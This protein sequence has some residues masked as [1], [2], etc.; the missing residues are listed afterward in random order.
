M[1]ARRRRLD[2]ELLVDSA[3]RAT[4]LVDLLRRLDEPLGAGPLRYLRQRLTHYGIDT[5]HFVPEA[6]PERPRRT[7]TR[8]MLAEAVADSRSLDEVIDLLGVP[9]YSSLRGYLTRRLA[10][11][12]IDTSHFSPV[13]GEP[14][15]RRAAAVSSSLAGM[16]R[17]LGLA[18][19]GRHRRQLR[20]LLVSHGINIAHFTGQGH[21]RGRPARNR[22][23]AEDILRLRAPG[24]ARTRRGLLHRAL[25]EQGVSYE[26]GACGTGDRWRDRPLVLE[27]DHVNGNPLD[28]RMD[29]LR[30]LC[31]SCH[32]QT[33][34]Y[35]RRNRAVISGAPNAVSGR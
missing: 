13:A 22:L 21:N 31:P 29:N 35:A 32:S 30:Y 14:E 11:F 5:G 1:T 23:S 12:G 10:H 15:L 27:I 24:A 18:D 2:R 16:L 33:R 17:V 6:L 19:T 20:R 34:T 25:Q 9:P 3:A 28:N 26:C 4:S 8:E 7:Y